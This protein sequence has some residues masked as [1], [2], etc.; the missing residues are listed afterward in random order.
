MNPELCAPVTLLIKHK[1]LL[2]L[3][4]QLISVHF[5][6]VIVCYAMKT[7]ACDCTIFP[8]RLTSEYEPENRGSRD[9]GAEKAPFRSWRSLQPFV[10]HVEVL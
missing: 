6:D 9:L 7:Q 3:K 5:F 10:I 1:R 4:M 2:V 8:R